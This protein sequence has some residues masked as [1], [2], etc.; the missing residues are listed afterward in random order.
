M[1]HPVSVV[2]K[3]KRSRRA[4][5][6]WAGLTTAATAPVA[7]YPTLVEPSWIEVRKINVPIPNLP[8]AFD[9]IAIAQLSDLHHSPATPLRFIQNAIDITRSLKPDL[10]ALT[11]DYVS[12][13]DFD[14]FP[15]VLDALKKL[16]PPLG[17]F[18]VRGNHD[19]PTVDDAVDEG[20]SQNGIRSLRNEI[21]TITKNGSAIDVAGVCDR[22][23]FAA[24]QAPNLSDDRPMLALC[25]NPDVADALKGTPVDLA[26]A[27]HTHGGQVNLPFI[28]PP[29]LPLIHKELVAG[30]YRI[31]KL[32]LYVNR[33]IGCLS[34]RVRFRSRPEI[35]LFTLR[36]GE[37]G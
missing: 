4:F 12:W 28:G 26:L 25:H 34:F 32:R 19:P 31:G 18:A 23:A 36:R 14:R 11:G 37:N 15:P 24:W 10:I 30:M 20:L 2:D 27:G 3:K 35:T 29:V 22:H 5:L 9:G 17:G 21:V 16:Q 1:S 8:A 7:L 6:K 13:G 33:G